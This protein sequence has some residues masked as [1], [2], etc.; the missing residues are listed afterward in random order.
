M[1]LLTSAIGALLS[2]HLT[3]AAPAPA[4]ALE[5]RLRPFSTFED[6]TV[7]VPP[8]NYIVPRT[9]YARTALL[10]N[11]DLLATW[12]N[13]SNETLEKTLV[14]FPI[15]KSSDGGETWVCKMIPCQVIRVYL[16]RHRRT[17]QM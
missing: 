9:L 6:V 14:Y 10:P 7:F 1:R 5:P 16:T 11:G 4:Q 17:S 13:Y 2:F 8:R 12:E 15:Y 3:F